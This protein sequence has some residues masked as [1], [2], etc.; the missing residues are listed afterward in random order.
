MAELRPSPFILVAGLAVL[1]GGA[2]LGRAP[3][4]PREG[5]ARREGREEGDGA[6][7]PTS[8]SRRAPAV[9]QEEQRDGAEAPRPEVEDDPARSP[10]RGAD[11]TR[12]PQPGA[13]A[14]FLDAADPCEPVVEQAVPA[15]FRQV[16]EA[17][18]TV[19]WPPDLVVHEPTSLAFTV[20]GLIREAAIATGTEPRE[21]LIVF[22][23]ASR[24][25][26]HLATGTPE[27]ASG[28][29]DGALHLVE[30]PTVD[31]GVRVST[32]R[33]EVMH[34]QLHSGVGCM[35]AWFN[36]GAA[37][38][39]AGRP[40]VATWISILREGAPFSFDALS[41]PTITDAPKED[42]PLLYAQSLAMLLFVVDRTTERT[43]ADVVHA[44]HEIEQPD[45]QLRARAL[46]KTLAPA[47]SAA[48]VRVSLAR[49]LFG[50]V[51]EL[52]LDALLAG[53]VCCSGE[54]HLSDLVCHATSDEAA[55][56]EGARC[57][58]H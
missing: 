33:H 43:L 21:R 5:G 17:D 14:T 11:D 13:R 30:E 42:A 28:V 32:L 1:V 23:Y 53:P 7:A 55:T 2:V 52:E 46:W 47:A 56:H 6:P 22:L 54:R 31:F 4:R 27:W 3:E 15:S 40:P 49:R 26:L 51:P 12:P 44:L 39:F 19:A 20:A 34:A 24:E 9:A 48:D 10:R 38:H 25:E 58:P 57:R 41:V 8:R 37:Q 16:T 29:Y 18:V 50:P 36:E 45:P 35:P